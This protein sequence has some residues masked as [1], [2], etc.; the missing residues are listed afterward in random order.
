MGYYVQL[1]D[2]NFGVPESTEVLA[3]IHRMDSEWHDLKRGGAYGPGGKEHSWFSW[4]PGLTSLH[5][6]QDVFEA[7]G[8]E[9]SVRDGKVWLGGYD[10]KT[11]QEELFLAA[12]APFVDEDSFTSWRGEDGELYGYTVR[13]GRLIAQQAYVVWEDEGPFRYV[14]YPTRSDLTKPLVAVSVDVYSD[15]PVSE[16]VATAV[17][18][19]V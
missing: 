3:A 7:L 9:V 15:V 17:K 11:G 10:N 8:F 5:T 16:Q 6:V 13:D 12:V 2:S 19:A 1:I 18:E 4:M 14:H